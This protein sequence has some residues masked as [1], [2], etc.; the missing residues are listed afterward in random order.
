MP[1]PTASRSGTLERNSCANP[2]E[3]GAASTAQ[4]RTGTAYPSTTPS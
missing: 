4:L 2:A 1:A 3:I